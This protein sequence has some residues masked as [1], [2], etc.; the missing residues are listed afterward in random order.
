MSS[1]KHKSQ[2]RSKRSLVVN[3][4]APTA[5]VTKNALQ[6][7]KI[8]AKASLV[9]NGE[10]TGRKFKVVPMVMIVEGVLN[11]SN[12]PLFYPKEEM[13]ICPEAWDHKPVVVNH[14]E[15]GVSACSPEELS[16][17]KVGYIFN[18][19]FEKVGRLK[20]EAWIDVDLANNVDKRIVEAIE[21]EETLELSTGLFT[22][23]E[24][25]PGTHD[26]VPYDAI[27]R[28]YRPD[29]LAILPDQIG[30][31]SK[32]AG[33]G[34][35]RNAAA[36]IDST[37]PKEMLE[38]CSFRVVAELTG[39]YNPIQPRDGSGTFGEGDEDDVTFNEGYT[40]QRQNL[41]GDPIPNP[42]SKPEDAKKAWNWQRGVNRAQWH[43]LRGVA[44]N[45]EGKPA[46]QN[47]LS[48]ESRRQQLYGKLKSSLCPKKEDYCS[49]WIEDVYSNKFIYSHQGKLF[50]QGYSATDTAVE[51]EGDREE[52][53]R[54]TEYRTP[55]GAFVGNRSTQTSE[56]QT[57]IVNMDKNK[58]I[59]SLIA[60]SESGWTEEDRATLTAFSAE[61]L[62]K[63]AA[64][65]GIKNKC[66]DDDEEEVSKKKM[67]K[68]DAAPAPA[69][70]ALNAEQT[71]ALAYGQRVLAAN[72]AK[73]IATIKANKANTL[74]DAVLNSMGID[75]LE[76]IAALAAVPAPTANAGEQ[77][78][79]PRPFFG[80]QA[81][82]RATTENA[83][84][85][86]ADDG[87][88]ALPMPTM[89]FGAD[90]KE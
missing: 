62:A 84:K 64:N 78:E 1:R 39:N 75:Q 17:R 45:A 54:V 20:A 27:A 26:G 31:C 2:T 73:A 60:N 63:L 47:E 19:K 3:K 58:I 15:S 24:N 41:S 4:S 29:H 42:Y 13:A 50:S 34:F 7:F 30:A 5:N 28:N 79:Q 82:V 49:A 21:S 80:G 10:M 12:G 74:S 40:A 18:T 55:K 77:V 68:N 57:T 52:V 6:T 86:G 36:K 16:K 71:E 87:G 35:I 43:A 65:A 76:S 33:A 56:K 46:T 37:I 89:N 32:A 14:P 85:G 53:V 59:N 11:G 23:N 25:T 88:E 90:S 22:D 66:E 48:L 83:A 9:R 44:M 51:L 38:A 8:N 61:K 69:A 70:P 67:K 72:K 81:E